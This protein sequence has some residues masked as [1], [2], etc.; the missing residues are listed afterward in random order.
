MGYLSSGVT[1]M[2]SHRHILR[3]DR[4]QRFGQSIRLLPM[5]PAPVRVRRDPEILVNTGAGF[6]VRWHL[7]N[8][9]WPVA[10]A[11]IGPLRGFHHAI[12]APGRPGRCTSM[13]TC[14]A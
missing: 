9:P 3:P 10:S 1:L 11:A 12:L 6:V 4:A 8:G 2:H 13:S 7:T 14:R 5:N